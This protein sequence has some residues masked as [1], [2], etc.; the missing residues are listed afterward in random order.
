MQSQFKD[1]PEEDRNDY[2]LQAWKK[3]KSGG[4]TTLLEQYTTGFIFN[5]LSAKKGIE[6]YGR[7]AEMTLINEFKQL[8][9]YE[10]FHGCK[11]S[12]LSYEQKKGSEYDKHY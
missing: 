9:E 7:E 12:D 11:A 6:K 3:Y 1:L 10:T 8:L 5:Q 2:L 4:K